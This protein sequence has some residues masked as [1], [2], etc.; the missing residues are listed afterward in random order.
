MFV[1]ILQNIR[2]GHGNDED[3]N[4]L[5]QKRDVDDG[6]VLFPKKDQVKEH[7]DAELDKLKHKEHRYDSINID[8]S[9]DD[10]QRFAKTLVLKKT[11]PVVLL[12]NVTTA[13]SS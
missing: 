11:M 8:N 7:N 13:L 1:G 2:M 5:L 9:G 6:V 10:D 4:I 12:S 3:L